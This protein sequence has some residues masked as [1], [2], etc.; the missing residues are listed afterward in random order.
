MGT[1]LANAKQAAAQERAAIIG[2]ARAERQVAEGVISEQGE[3]INLL[4][5]TQAEA[6]RRGKRRSGELAVLQARLPLAPRPSPCPRLPGA[7]DST[8]PPPS[9]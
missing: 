1:E 6:E 8:H 5:R 9:T 7:I 3:V 2:A 4:R